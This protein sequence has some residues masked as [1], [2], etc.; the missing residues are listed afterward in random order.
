MDHVLKPTRIKSYSLNI[1]LFHLL[2]FTLGEH[3]AKSPAHPG[4][5][6]S[7]PNRQSESAASCQPV[8]KTGTLA[9]SK[10]QAMLC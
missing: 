10:D 7:I 1:F 6:L 2:S 9:E 5:R 4:G 3:T 8:G